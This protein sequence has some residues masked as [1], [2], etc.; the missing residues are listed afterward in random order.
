VSSFEIPGDYGAK[1]RMEPQAEATEL[2]SVASGTEGRDV[3]LAPAAATAW[4]RMRDA[5]SGEGIIL[6]AISGFRST[7]RQTEIIELKVLAGDTIDSILKSVAAPGYSE[8][9]TGRAIDIGIPGETALTEAFAL[10]PAFRWLEGHAHDFGFRLSYPKGN[11]H[12][13]GYEPW[14]WCLQVAD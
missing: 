12:G 1:R 14:H 9:H 10:T 6:L 7:E 11:V 3:R 13:M 8:H 2:V 4:K 5:A